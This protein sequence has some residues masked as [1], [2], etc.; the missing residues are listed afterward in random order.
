MLSLIA[1]LT[2]ATSIAVGGESQT[3]EGAVGEAI[4]HPK[5]GQEPIPEFVAIKFDVKDYDPLTGTC[6]RG[7]LQRNGE[8]A[9][10]GVTTLKSPDKPKWV[11]DT[12][13]PVKSSPVVVNGILY[14]GSDKGKFYALNP[15]TGKELW[16]IP[17]EG[18]VRSSACVKDGVVYFG[19]M[20]G[21]LYAADAKSGEVKWK[22]NAS[23]RG[24]IE[25]GVGVL[26]NTVFVNIWTPTGFRVSDGKK[27]WEGRQG[28]MYKTQSI[29]LTDKYLLFNKASSY[30]VYSLKLADEKLQFNP[31]SNGMYSRSTAAVRDNMVC[32]TNA[33]G[34]GAGPGYSG[35]NLLV[36]ETFKSIFKGHPIEE[37]IEA[38]DRKYCLSSPAMDENN[39]YIGMDSGFF[40]AFDRKTGK[41]LWEFKASNMIRVPVNFTSEDSTVYF[42]DNNGF[43]YA[44]NT[45]DG[46]LRWKFKT[47]GE[48]HSAVWPT[49]GVVYV[50]SDDGKVYA[51]EAK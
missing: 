30:R 12:G 40:Y 37:H 16:N 18:G 26:Y 48:V 46:S 31:G 41:K 27:V 44:L 21:Y 29:T 22:V 20:D 28:G 45:E 11:F 8:F 9:T 33:G 13:G 4:P 42:G 19:G 50:G 15:A 3:L 17:V 34:I 36:V 1:L 32:F 49:S 39:I 5:G 24:P 23:K 6:H 38:K 51:L 25:G 10:R 35:L 47:G 43:V 14:V 2:C 7:S